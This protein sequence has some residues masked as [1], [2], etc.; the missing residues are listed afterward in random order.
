MHDAVGHQVPDRPRVGRARPALTGR[1][2]QRG[3]LD[4]GERVGGQL[5]DRGDDVLAVEFVTGAAHADELRQTEQLLP[6]LPRQNRGQC[7][8]A[9]DEVKI[10]VGVQRTQIFQRVI[11]VGGSGTININATDREPGIRGGG[12]DRHEV[13]VLGGGHGATN[14]LP[15]PPGRDEHHF[16]EAEQVGDLAGGDEVAVVDGVECSAHHAEPAPGLH[17]WPAYWSARPA[18]AGR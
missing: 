13:A 3:H 4:E 5:I 1:D 16:V 12:D 8:G 6:V 14:L 18:G 15:G 7:V 11:G 9:G 2:G 17:E 10:A